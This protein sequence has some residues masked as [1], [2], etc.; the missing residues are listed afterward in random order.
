[1]RSPGTAPVL[2][3]GRSPVTGSL[4]GVWTTRPDAD[5]GSPLE[6]LLSP[7]PERRTAVKESPVNRAKRRFMRMG[8]PSKSK[9]GAR[10]GCVPHFPGSCSWEWSGPPEAADGRGPR[11]IGLS[12]TVQTKVS[13][14]AGLNSRYVPYLLPKKFCKAWY[15]YRSQAS[16]SCRPPWM[17]A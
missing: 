14:V 12:I 7:H 1:M 6:E 2:S 11:K 4:C 17:M 13:R 15:R 3:S 9:S 10:R 16:M 8:Y 5:G